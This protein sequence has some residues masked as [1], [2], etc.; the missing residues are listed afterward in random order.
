MFELLGNA[1]APVMVIFAI[2]FI[3]SMVGSSLQRLWIKVP[4]NTAAVFYGRKNKDKDGNETGYNIITGGAKL[5]IPLVEEVEMMDL[6]LISLDIKVD[7]VANKD[8][9]LVNLK[10]NANVFFLND[11]FSLQNAAKKFLGKPRE[12]VESIIHKSLEGHLRGI[13]GKMTLEEI[14]N[15]RIKFGQ[16]VK[17]E[18]GEDLEKFGLD[19]VFITI[20]EVTDNDHYIEALGQKRTAEVKRDAE[21]GRAEAESEATQ[22]SSTAE[23]VAATKKAQNEALIAKAEKEKEVL[24]AEYAAETAKQKA[25]SDQA[26]PLAEAEKK[27]EVVAAEK[28][29]IRI[30]TEKETEI[31]IAEAQKQEKVLLATKIRPAEAEKQSKIIEAEADQQKTIIDAEA[32]REATIKAAEGT[33]EKTKLEATAE[34]EKLLAVG[35]AEAEVIR[36]K[37]E[38]EAIGIT[39]KAEA[40]KLMNDVGQQIQLIEKIGEVGPGI[41]EGIAKIASEIAAPI[42]NVDK[43]TITDFGG[44]GNALGNFTKTVPAILAQ[45]FE[46]CKAVGIDPTGL[47]QKAKL[48]P[49]E[50]LNDPKIKDFIKNNPAVQEVASTIIDSLDQTPSQPVKE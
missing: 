11:D 29:V 12:E 28:E 40:Y 16:N 46:G 23:Q 4:P 21:I 17:S 49:E 39:K 10:G 26:G 42:G 48:N 20:S 5:R 2:L 31:A 3:F 9:V 13:A 8:G 50:L 47:Y 19:V 18:A 34:A 15:N 33:A 25:I 41:A 7:N 37:L 35:K 22:Q 1:L 36:M 24:K 14:I 38:A 32:S 44:Q 6:S 43:I 45:L 27:K 30:Q